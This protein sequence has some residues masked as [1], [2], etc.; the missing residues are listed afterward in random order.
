M[1]AKKNGAPP[2]LVKRRIG[3]ALIQFFKPAEF[4]EPHLPGQ[5]IPQKRAAVFYLEEKKPGSDVSLKEKQIIK[6]QY[7]EEQEEPIP[8]LST[9]P[10]HWIELVTF[11][12]SAC[13]RASLKIKKTVA[14]NTYKTA[15]ASKGKGRLK[16]IGG[17][18][19]KT[20]TILED[21]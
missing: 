17:I 20:P 2:P 15:L 12:L 19:N 10:K 4:T 3:K 9:P 11:L 7:E 6:P 18:I 1:A 21:D 14:T 8:G 16:T 13:R 5:P